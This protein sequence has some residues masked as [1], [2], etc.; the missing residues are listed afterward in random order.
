MRGDRPGDCDPA[1]ITV[2]RLGH[3]ILRDARIT[4]H[5]C[6]TGRAFGA[7][8]AIVSGEKDDGVL[9]SV[10]RVCE[11]WGGNFSVS[12]EK[13]F[14][15]VIENFRGVKVHLTVYGMPFEDKVGMIRKVA[16]DKDVLVVVGGEKVPH[17]VY[18]LVDYNVSVTSQPHSEVAALSVFLHEF[19]GGKEL[20]N[21]FEG[22]KIKVVPQERGKKL[23]E[24]D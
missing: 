9:R 11:R 23:I 12:Y 22:A 6:L 10:S 2:L 19:F 3:R 4:T 21:E 5:V 17:D 20:E 14:R 13:N 18:Y 7:S 8:S 1:M 15:K 16:K 24:K